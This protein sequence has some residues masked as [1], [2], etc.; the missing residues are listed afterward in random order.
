MHV[1][2]HTKRDAVVT[3]SPREPS[4]EP[5]T[6]ALADL[7]AALD[8]CID[9]LGHARRRAEELLAERRRGASWLTIVTAESRPLVVETVSAV[10]GTLARAGSSWR[11][12]E[13]HAL[14]SETVSINRIAAL[15]GVTR[16][17]ISA[18]LRERGDEEKDRVGTTG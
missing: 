1:K 7:V 3:T 9:G 12:E 10:M 15:F 5:A 8:E 17:R 13:A 18:L 4:T 6:E 14:R 16:Q 2:A 11:R